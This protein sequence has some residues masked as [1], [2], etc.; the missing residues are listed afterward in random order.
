MALFNR[1]SDKDVRWMLFIVIFVSLWWF[2]V[3]YMVGLW[4]AY[5]GNELHN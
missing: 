3:G 4:L 5:G 2:G 1:F